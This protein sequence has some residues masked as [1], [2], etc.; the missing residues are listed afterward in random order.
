M[1]HVQQPDRHDGARRVTTRIRQMAERT[2]WVDVAPDASGV[3]NFTPDLVEEFHGLLDQLR[4]PAAVAGAIGHPPPYAVIQSSHPTYFS[5][6]AC[7]RTRCAAW[8]RS[9]PGRPSSRAGWRPSPWSRG[10]RWAVVSSWR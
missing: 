7:A 6:G 8:K 10:A 1:N 4:I 9:W 5:Q 2:L 3:H